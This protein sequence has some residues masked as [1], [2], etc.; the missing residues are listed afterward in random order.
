MA[1]SNDP[2]VAP[3]ARVRVALAAALASA[4]LSAS[5]AGADGIA[6]HSF[7]WHR[8]EAGQWLLALTVE[9]E[10]GWHV[11]W[12]NP[13]DSGDAPRFELSL[14][15][16]WHAGAT[17]YPRPEATMIDDAPFYGYL[18]RVTYLV[19]VAP[20]AGS[21][22]PPADA[23]EWAV[24]ARLMACKERCTVTACSA[25]GTWPPSPAGAEI[26]L[27]GGAVGG[28][29]LPLTA[30]QAK[31]E[32]RVTDGRARI[33]GPAQ[34]ASSVRFIPANVPGMLV[35]LPEG[36]AAI[37]GTVEGGRF[38][39]EFPLRHPGEGDGQPAVAGLVLLGNRPGDPCVRLAVPRAAPAAAPSPPA[40][41]PG[42]SPAQPP[43]K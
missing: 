34:G 23:G 37:P 31:V 8:G 19:P 15:A 21:A 24:T 12:E 1:R 3:A 42:A 38:R 18:G 11:Y 32:A 29:S 28:A 39:L 36:Q 26:A 20:A 13:G 16:G 2:R 9:P 4:A 27:R 22:A 40:E 14:P 41:I 10:A 6:R 5:P 25:R 30:E 35:D 17:V 43:A 7:A 33:E